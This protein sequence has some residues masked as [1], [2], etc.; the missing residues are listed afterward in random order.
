MIF[1]NITSQN[2]SLTTEEFHGYVDAMTTCFYCRRTIHNV[3]SFNILFFPLEEVRKFKGYYDYIKIPIIDC[4]QYYERFDNCPSFYCNNCNCNYPAYSN[5]KI[6]KVPKTL[7]I[8]LNSGRGLEYNINITFEEYL[9]LKNFV[10]SFG[11]PN[12]YKLKVISHFGSNDDGGHFIAYCKNCNVAKW[13]K[14]N[15]QFVDEVPFDDVINRGM[16]YVLFYSH[17]ETQNDDDIYD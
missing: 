11:S 7:I 15:G 2:D 12:Y 1:F 6:I 13:Y 14:F 5:S 4:F 16:P 17:I 9:D 8:N 3:Q 10:C